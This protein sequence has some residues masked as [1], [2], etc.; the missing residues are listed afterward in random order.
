MRGGHSSVSPKDLI[1]SHRLRRHVSVGN[2]N[3]DQTRAALEDFNLTNGLTDDY[4]FTEISIGTP[5][6]TFK[7]WMD[8]GVSDVY[9]A[10]TACTIEQCP[11]FVPLYDET[12]SSTAVNKTTTVSSILTEGGIAYGYIVADTITMGSIIVSQAEFLEA[13]RI[14]TLILPDSVSGLL[15]FGFDNTG[16]APIVPFWRT[17]MNSGGAAPEMGFW[18]SRVLGT[19][20]PASEEPGG[21]F[22]FGGVNASLFSGDVEFLDLVPSSMTCWALNLSRITAQNKSISVT[23]SSSLATFDTVTTFILG[24]PQDVK[25]IWATIPGSSF[26]DSS[27]LYQFP[28]NT[29]VKVSVS[30]GGK[31]W[32]IDPADINFGPASEKSQCLGAI[33]PLD[34]TAFWTFGI[35]F[36]KNVYAVLRNSPPSVGFAELSTIAG[37]T[38]LF[39]CCLHSL[40]CLIIR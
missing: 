15:G 1:A 9:V 27:G 24:P 5:P 4:Y 2:S 16:Q 35:P 40:L 13:T 33:A 14:S 34:G 10:G 25:A 39:F 36:M 8:I 17:L 22:T 3:R 29:T 21:V 38:G 11:S 20:D 6:Q 23:K 30:F 18:I 37:G 32:P 26:D 31:M 19:S 28:C 7:M 12:L